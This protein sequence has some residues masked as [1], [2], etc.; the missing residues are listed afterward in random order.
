[1]A[2]PSSDL[3]DGGDG[4]RSEVQTS[5]VASQAG[6]V[7]IDSLLRTV[8]RDMSSLT[9]L[10]T[11]LASSVQRSTVGSSAVTRNMAEFSTSIALHGLSLAVSSEVVGSTALV[12]SSRTW[13]TSKS[14][15]RNKSAVESTTRGAETTTSTW[16]G[17]SC[18]S[19]AWA[20]TS[21]MSWLTAVVASTAGTGSTKS[22][23]WAISLDVS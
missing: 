7:T 23:S 2:N 15:T 17:T 4:C 5:D 11:S 21:Q 19:W 1:M 8:T 16:D 12:A 18:S 22:E 13:P 10:V 9:A 20:R 3:N 6:Q 14:S